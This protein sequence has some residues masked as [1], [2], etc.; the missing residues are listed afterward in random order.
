M[1]LYCP[2]AAALAVFVSSNAIGV[3]GQ[4]P[5]LVARNDTSA[6]QVYPAFRDWAN[7]V[8][9]LTVDTSDCWFG[10]ID[11]PDGSVMC[12]NI[13]QYAGCIFDMISPISLD[14][15]LPAVGSAIDGFMNDPLG[16]LC[17]SPRTRSTR[18]STTSRPV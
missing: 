12:L 9:L 16:S 4:A 14:E 15:I 11:C 18:L 6:I 10:T 7:S 5:V 3:L 2:T 13:F 17:A 8:S 1:K